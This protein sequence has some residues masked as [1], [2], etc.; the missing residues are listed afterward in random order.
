MTAPP[1]PDPPTTGVLVVDKPAGV[2]SHDVVAMARR[3]LRLRR[4]G[5]TGTLDP[6]ATG[7]L[8]LCLGTATRLVDYFHD[9]PKT[10][11]GEGV[12]GVV[13]TTQDLTGHVVAETDASGITEAQ[14]RAAMARF[15]GEIEQVPPMVSAVK[16]GGRRL[17]ERARAGEEVARPA[18]RVLIHSFT[19]DRFVPGRHPQFEFTVVCSSGTYVRTLVHDLGQA[20]GCG[21]ALA[22]LRRT[23]IGSLRVEEAVPAGDLER[24]AATSELRARILAPAAALAHLPAV[25]LSPEAVR[26]VVHGQPVPAPAP[27]PG[28]P[29]RLLDGEGNLVAIA[30]PLRQANRWLLVPK[31]VFGVV[32]AAN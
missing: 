19:L 12:L 13:T 10:Y 18:R 14:L 25:T 27:G 9:L 32:D 22:R 11:V 17:Y 16:V 4:I 29:V 2:T 3:A 6:M 28:A 15:Q 5:H 31:K 7:V 26:S 8:V 21:A 1:Q 23:A 30:E 20:L 24:L